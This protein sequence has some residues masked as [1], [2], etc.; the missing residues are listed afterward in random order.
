MAYKPCHIY[1]NDDSFV[2]RLYQV[3]LHHELGAEDYT[4]EEGLHY[5]YLVHWPVNTTTSTLS[6]TRNG[7]V[8]RWRKAHNCNICRNRQSNYKCPKCGLFYQ[9]KWCCSAEYHE[10]VKNYIQ[11][12]IEADETKSVDWTPRP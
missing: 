3:G 12:K 1:T 2:L 4:E 10:N 5:H 9:F 6:P 11:R 8:G 7:A